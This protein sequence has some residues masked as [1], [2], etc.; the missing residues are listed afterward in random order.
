VNPSERQE[1]V[2]AVAQ[3]QLST[4]ELPGPPCN[5]R[6][7]GYLASVGQSADDEI[8]WCSAFVN[9][10]CQKAGIDGTGKANAKSWL[11]WGQ[12]VYDP[13]PGD[14]V[15]FWRR[16]PASWQGHVAFF[17]KRDGDLVFCLGG[18]QHNAVCSAAYP[19]NRVLAYRRG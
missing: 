1:R 5:D 19:L 3:S 14:L 9:W 17:E 4:N 8:P 7:A 2:Y 16:D 6:I 10:C 18:N 15:V 11:T 12:E 13:Q